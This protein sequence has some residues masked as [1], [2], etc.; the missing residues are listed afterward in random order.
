MAK[1]QPKRRKRTCWSESVTRGG[2][3]VRVYEAYPGSN[4][5]R[6]IWLP[7][8]SGSPPGARG[9]E[10]KRTLGHKDR[11]RALDQVTELIKHLGTADSGVPQDEITLGVLMERYLASRKHAAKKERTSREDEAKL[12]RVVNFLGSTRRAASLDEELV[13]QFVEARRRGDPSLLHIRK[14]RDGKPVPVRDRA[15]EADLVAL[16]TMLRWGCV[17]KNERGKTLLSA[18]P[19]KGVEFP[20]EKNPRQPVANDDDLEVLL[21]VG[22]QVHPMLRPALIIANDLGRR[23]SAW[24]QLRWKDIHLGKEQFGAIHWPGET[25]KN[26]IA[27]F[28]PITAQVRNTLLALRPAGVKPEDWVF[29]APHDPARPVGRRTFYGWLAEAYEV[30]GLEPEEGSLWHA[31]RRAWVTRRKGYPLTDIAAA[32]GW[33]D[34]R[35]LRSYLKEDPETVR[36]VVLEPTHQLRRQAR[37]E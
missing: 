37:D 2:I 29:P 31:I 9:K 17:T 27:L 13:L 5:Y 26:G 7:P 33:K 12:R 1:K 8:P 19:L 3:T 10:D 22:D 34:E 4:L 21:N 15:V 32:G 30:A 36:K 6:S 25:D 20:R 18:D 28:R 14:G 11:D 23:T 35:S 24:R 16:H